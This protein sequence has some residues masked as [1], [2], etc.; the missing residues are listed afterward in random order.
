MTNYASLA[1]AE[2][3]AELGR[4][5]EIPDPELIEEIISRRESIAPKVLRVFDKLAEYIDDDADW[6]QAVLAGRI[7]LH[8]REAASL[9]TFEKMYMRGDDEL[10]WF[11]EKPSVLG[12]QAIPTFRNVLIAEPREGWHYGRALASSIIANIAWQYPDARDDAIDALHSSLPKLRED[13]SLDYPA[14]REPDHVWSGVISDLA[15]LQ[16]GESREVALA[17]FDADLVDPL[18][19][20]RKTYLRL[21]NGVGRRNPNT[22]EFDLVAETRRAWEFE[23]TRLRRIARE[24]ERLP[25]RPAPPTGARPKVGRNDPCPCGSGKKY[26][27]CCGKK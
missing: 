17:L 5:G 12:A 7:L 22:T 18:V 11:E 24:A 27:Y 19:I 15:E 14:E 10:E 8:W 6:N 1:D 2:L 21:L 20:S 4:A 16:D 26:K 3:V 25:V 9:S 13:G 23:Q